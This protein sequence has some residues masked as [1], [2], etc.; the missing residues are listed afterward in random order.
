[1]HATNFEDVEFFA[2]QLKDIDYQWYEQ[3]EKLRVDDAELVVWVDFLGVFIDHFFPQQLRKSK[4]EEFMNLKLGKMSV[5]K[6][7][8]K[9]Q[10][11]SHN[12]QMFVSA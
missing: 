12:A 3:W 5:M 7:T 10:Q 1:M 9:F 4:A 11:F 8:L 2:H 6:Y